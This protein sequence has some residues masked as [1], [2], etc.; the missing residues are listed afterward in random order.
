MKNQKRKFPYWIHLVLG[1]I[2]IIVGI[3]L[4]SGVSSIVWIGGGLMMM[5][6]GVLNKGKN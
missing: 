6:I 4:Y 1:L 2:W 5:V 3:V